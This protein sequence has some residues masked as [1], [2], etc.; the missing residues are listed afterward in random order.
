MKV[1][2]IRDLE[3]LKAKGMATLCP[4]TIKIMV[5][6]ATCGQSMG[7]GA[8][9][10]AIAKGVQ[11]NKI[12]ALVKKTGCIGMC[13]EE[14]LVDVLLPGSPRITYSHMDKEK[15]AALVDALRKGVSLAGA[16]GRM[17]EDEF[18]LED[19]VRPYK[20]GKIKREKVSL[21]A[22]IKFSYFLF[23]NCIERWHLR[24]LRLR[25][26]CGLS[27]PQIGADTLFLAFFYFLITTFPLSFVSPCTISSRK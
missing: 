21:E 7:A 1:S 20:K 26:L 5:G 10:D 17:D 3:K 2:S 13:H 12:N 24:C 8:V 11:K 19:T 23:F 4:N 16:L 14:P 9:F 25:W 15:A 22:Y 6:M 27:L 18:L